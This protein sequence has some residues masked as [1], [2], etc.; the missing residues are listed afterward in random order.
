M[1]VRVEGNTDG[2]G[3]KQVNQ[4][5]S[6]ARAGAIVS[7]LV[8]RG[9]AP[10]RLLARGNGAR[11]PIASNKTPEGRAANRRTDI[12]FIKRKDSP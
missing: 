8:S 1:S 10:E 7:Y 11:A 2:V 4:A 6:E 9:V 5:L 3:D 12:L